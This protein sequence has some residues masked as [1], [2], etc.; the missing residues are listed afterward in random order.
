[1][2]GAVAPPV[3]DRGTYAHLVEVLQFFRVAAGPTSGYTQAAQALVDQGSISAYQRVP[4]AAS[5]LERWIQWK[6]SGMAEVVPFE[7]ASRIEAAGDL[8]EQVEVLLNDSKVHPA[9]PIVL[10]GAALEERLRALVLE[11]AVDVVGKPGLDSYA[12]ALKK[13]EI[14]DGQEAKQITA[15]AGLRNQAAH[16]ERLADLDIK[17]ARLMAAGINLFLQQHS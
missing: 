7:L 15:W 5:L 17:E 9:A 1:M 13:A 2:R 10:A 16:G 14:V 3:E 12:A 11:H 4:D 8:M 6:K